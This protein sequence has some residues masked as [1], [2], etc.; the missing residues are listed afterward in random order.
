M[1]RGCSR[2]GVYG[3]LEEPVATPA[4]EGICRVREGEEGEQMDNEGCLQM[5]NCVL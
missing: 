4:V 1:G 3:S 2:D 5:V